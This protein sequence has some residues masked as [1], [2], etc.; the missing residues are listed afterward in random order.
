M[1]DDDD[2]RAIKL[3][4]DHAESCLLTQGRQFYYRRFSAV[5]PTH[6]VETPANR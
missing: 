4:T 3:E 5:R 2:A 1:T 6:R